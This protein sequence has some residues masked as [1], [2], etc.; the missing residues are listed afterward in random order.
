[1]HYILSD[2]AHKCSYTGNITNQS[3]S[4]DNSFFSLPAKL[5]LPIIC[6]I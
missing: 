1:M 3:K 4:V 2:I 6:I 5:Y